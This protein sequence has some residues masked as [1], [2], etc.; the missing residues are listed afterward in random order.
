[1]CDTAKLAE[2][3]RT[4][5]TIRQL[6]AKGITGRCARCGEPGEGIF[7]CSRCTA[8]LSELWPH[9]HQV[10]PEVRLCG[11][12]ATLRPHRRYCDGCSARHKKEAMREAARR[13]RQSHV[14]AVIS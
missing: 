9:R 10:K 14:P 6:L 3:A 8:Y 5:P 4:E 12:G 11:C 2:Q 13:Y 7:V 1:M